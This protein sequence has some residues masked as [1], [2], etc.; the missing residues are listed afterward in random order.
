MEYCLK[1]TCKCGGKIV[2]VVLKEKSPYGQ[3]RDIVSHGTCDQCL[4]NV[5]MPPCELREISGLIEPYRY[6]DSHNK[7]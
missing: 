3:A 1:D 2:L 5:V 7:R 4:E 6:S